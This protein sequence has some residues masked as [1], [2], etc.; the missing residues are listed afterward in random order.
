MYLWD[1]GAHA[2]CLLYVYGIYV[3]Q[4]NTHYHGN[5]I[6]HLWYLCH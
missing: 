5:K 4:L 3:Q 6:W 1:L 2:K